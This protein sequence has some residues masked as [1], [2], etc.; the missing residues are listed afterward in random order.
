MIQSKAEETVSDVWKLILHGHVHLQ[1][2]RNCFFLWRKV[3]VRL[4]K[5]V[6]RLKNCAQGWEATNC[7]PKRTGK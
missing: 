3:A 6:F 4:G 1:E 2:G 5:I 7:L